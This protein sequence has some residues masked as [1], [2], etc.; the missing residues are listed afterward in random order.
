MAGR[1]RWGNRKR[2]GKVCAGGDG[3]RLAPWVPAAGLNTGHTTRTA[4]ASAA[5]PSAPAL[6]PSAPAASAPPSSALSKGLAISAY[7]SSGATAMMVGPRHTTMPRGLVRSVVQ[8]GSSGSAGEER[9]ASMVSERRARARPPPLAGLTAH[10]LDRLGEH[11]VLELVESLEDAADC[12]GGAVEGAS[13]LHAAFSTRGSH[14]RPPVN[15]TR[16]RSFIRGPRP[17]PRARLWLAIVCSC[18]FV[19]HDRDAGVSAAGPAGGTEGDLRSLWV[20]RG[21]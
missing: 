17:R 14:S 6:A 7:A 10:V 15:L 21:K 5:A 11:N 20:G 12:G 4:Q 1:L 2:E 13:G 18:G 8:S 19:A 16:T 9:R 3:E